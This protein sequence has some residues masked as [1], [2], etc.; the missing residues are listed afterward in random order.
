MSADQK[1]IFDIQELGRA[2]VADLMKQIE[3]APE[4]PVRRALELKVIDQKRSTEVLVLREI[5]AQALKRGDV[6]A[7]REANEAIDAIL[8]PKAP[9]TELT[10]RPAPGIDAANR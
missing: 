5:S 6:A 4:G 10:P 8:H 3:A 1:A 7:S 2:Q 9:S